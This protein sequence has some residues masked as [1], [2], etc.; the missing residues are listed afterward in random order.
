MFMRA[1]NRSA[2]LAVTLAPGI[3]LGPYKILAA[4]GAG[5]MDEVYRAR[6]TRLGRDMAIKV[7]SPRFAATPEVRARFEREARTILPLGGLDPRSLRQSLH[8]PTPPPQ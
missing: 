8:G 3:Q 7:L 4:I 2:L 5:W 6:D 1:E